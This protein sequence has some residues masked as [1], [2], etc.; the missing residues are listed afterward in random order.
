[1]PRQLEIMPGDR[2]GAMP[3]GSRNAGEATEAAVKNEPAGDAAV[4]EA[5]VIGSGVTMC[6]GVM[7]GIL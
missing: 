6:S 3:R 7:V 1:M 5:E 4:G 2:S